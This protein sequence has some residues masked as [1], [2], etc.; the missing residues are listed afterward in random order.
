M[1]HRILVCALFILALVPGAAAA[2]RVSGTVV[3][4]GN[5]ARIPGALVELV[6]D[7]GTVRA[8]VLSDAAG[9]FGVQTAAAGRY[10][11][12]A[13]RVGF[14]PVTSPPMELAAG[15]TVEYTLQATA[16]R[17]S[18]PAITTSA[19]RRCGAIRGNGAE[20]VALWTEARKALRSAAYTSSELAYRYRVNS[21]VRQ[22]DPRTFATLSERAQTGE[23]VRVAP[24]A[25]V[26]AERLAAVGYAEAAGD[27]LLF[28]APD[29]EILLS[30]A[31]LDT[32][33][34]NAQPA[35]REHP[36]MVGLAFAPVETGERVDV[37][38]VLW[39]DA[40][41]AE[42]RVLEY[43]YAG[44]PPQLSTQAAG[45]RVEFR[46]L[47]SGGWIVSRWRIRMPS[48]ASRYRPNSPT[49]PGAT[50]ALVSGL[51]EQS[52]EVLE[53]RTRDGE[54][55][56][57]A[58]MASVAGMVF[59]S[60]RS[61]PLAGARVSLA[62][63]E[64][65]AVS[66]S[67]GRYA[68]TGVPEG[69][70]SLVF[71]HPRLDSLRFTPDPVPVTANPPGESAQDLA[72][73]TLGR[74]L[75][76][77]CLTPASAETVA[78]GGVVTSRES[79]QPMAGIP[80]RASWMGAGES[81]DTLRAI[82]VSDF[83]GMY[84]FCALPARVAVRVAALLPGAVA[85]EL[86]LEP[87]RPGVH[88]LAV[89]RAGPA[90][91][92]VAGGQRGRV[93]LR[94]VDAS[95]SRPI[96]GV[97]VRMG[98]G[99]PQAT[100]DRRGMVTLANVPAGSYGIEFRHPTYGLGTARVTVSGVAPTEMELRVPKRPVILEPLVV[101]ARRVLPGVFNQDR[102]GRRLDIM[103]RHEIGRLGA[104]RSV[105]DVALRFPGV[106]VKYDNKGNACVES[107]RLKAQLLY[108]ADCDAVQ[109]VL[110]DMVVGKG[111]DFVTSIPL[112]D[113]E[114]V[115]FLKPTE[116]FASWGY[117]GQRGILLV[118]T[119]GNGPTAQPGP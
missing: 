13:E 114:S 93:I 16:E 104:A 17:V 99:V 57:L 45:G 3:E 113:V 51:R 89:E 111:S 105:A 84:R 106:M 68:L 19:G 65:T 56:D 55:V 61:R 38:G 41:T 5:G 94:L 66:D 34:F 70:Y 88:D 14:R 28:H 42:L 62:G 73:P 117:I 79:G 71:A 82:A 25:A 29:A 22:L 101:Q 102:R 103:D 43:G 48:G 72:I 6:G 90:P 52:A 2:Q 110:D 87:G 26:P 10:T 100:S 115:I 31:F 1:P 9:R 96:Q 85:S 39:M 64:R 58:A 40:A 76:A 11:L 59:D 44:G 37:R 74:V 107:V 108:P 49:P 67:A 50:P 112:H 33:C 98:A 15:Q 21:R 46:R 23:T 75:T 4:Q 7:D 91:A 63:T 86:R 116:A 12:R 97:V 54:L 81:G 92:E 83:A 119:R 53:I 30:D 109:L 32:H 47:P 77:S 27:T 24:F 36:G 69:V 20:V 60:T 95:T 118:Y 8:E 78:L 18:L 35:D 80:V